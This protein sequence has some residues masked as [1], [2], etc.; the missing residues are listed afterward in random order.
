MKTQDV[1]CGGLLVGLSVVLF[2]QTTGSTGPVFADD[3]DPMQYPRALIIL[4]GVMGALLAGKGL[5]ARAERTDMPIF[6]RHTLG[7]MAVLILYAAFFITLGFF[8]TSV[9][10][11]L[12]IALIMGYRRLPLLTGASVLS[13]VLIWLMYVYILRIPLPSGSLF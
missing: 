1:L 3:I 4:L 11:C 13:V 7:V 8:I 10:A 2:A 9:L 12:G 6:T 5:F